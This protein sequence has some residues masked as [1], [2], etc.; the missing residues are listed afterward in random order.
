MSLLI[1]D[2]QEHELEQ[3]L[4]MNNAAGPG[5]LPIDA[6]RV[7]RFYR[8]AE[9]FRIAER[10]GQLAGFLVAFGHDADHESG[11]FDWFRENASGPFL[12]IDRIVVASQRRGGGVGR[13]FYAD[14]QGYA[15]QRYPQLACE[16]FMR[17]GPDPVLLFHGAL[18][19]QEIGQRRQDDGTMASM[20][21]RELCSHEWIH[22][23][24]GNR[25][26]DV[27]WIGRPRTPLP[28]PLSTGT[29]A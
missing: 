6:A 26:P 19:F 14:V 2:V 15:E 3:V 22:Q 23:T 25:L 12:Y 16:V 18:G 17:D 8:D 29:H 11:N 20:L 5:I 4:A 1:R 21:V 10:N 24:Y 28:A 27:P 9:Y 7:G 13:A